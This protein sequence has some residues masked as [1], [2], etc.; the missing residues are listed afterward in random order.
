MTDRHSGYLVTLG[1]DIR[2]E[3]AEAVIRA[4]GMIKGVMSVKPII[5]D[6]ALMIAEER[7]R[8]KYE[9][10][11]WRLYIHVRDHGPESVLPEEKP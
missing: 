2:E 7:Q 5:H 11:L 1:H 3:D 9:A 6:H 4:L 10:M 8:E